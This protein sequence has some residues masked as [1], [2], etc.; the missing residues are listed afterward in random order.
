VKKHVPVQPAGDLGLAGKT[1]DGIG[2][3]MISAWENPPAIDAIESALGGLRGC[4]AVVVDVRPNSGGG[5]DLAQRVAAWF[6]EGTKVYAKHRTRVRAGKNGFD[7]VMQRALTGNKDAARRL[8][9]PIAVLTSRYVMS[10]NESFVMMMRQARDCTVVGQPTYGSSGC[11]KPFELPNGVR[12]VVPSWQDLR[13]DGTCL[14]GE[15][16]APDVLVE[17]TAKQLESGDPILEKAL[18]ILRDKL[19]SPKR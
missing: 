2:Y 13:L 8:D 3:V 6:V 11:P 16:L 1:E 7:P 10:S 4:K 18:S 12:L 15:G 17:C 9:V 14:E 19:G 5:E